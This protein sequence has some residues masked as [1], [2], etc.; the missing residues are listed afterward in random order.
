MHATHFLTAMS[1]RVF[2]EHATP[3]KVPREWV[4]ETVTVLASGPSMSAEVAEMVRGKTR[5]IVD[6][7][8]RLAPWADVLYAA[9]WQ[10]WTHENNADARH[11]AGTKVTL[12]MACPFPEVKLLRAGEDY[13]ISDSSDALNTCKNSGWQAINLAYL[14]GAKRILLCGFDMR[15]GEDGRSHHFGEHPKGL[16][17]PLLSTFRHYITRSAPELA[18]RDVEVINCTMRSALTCFKKL[19][20]EEALCMHA[21]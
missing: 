16:E 2:T 13:G 21:C 11:F 15:K 20:L 17:P 19:P 6:D 5:V 9:D 7:Q 8:F 1:S 4:G 18:R 12:S 14:Y 3:W 10:W